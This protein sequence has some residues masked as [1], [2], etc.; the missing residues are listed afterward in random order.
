MA[1]LKEKPKRAHAVQHAM[2]KTL[3]CFKIVQTVIGDPAP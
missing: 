1:S 2:D 3:K